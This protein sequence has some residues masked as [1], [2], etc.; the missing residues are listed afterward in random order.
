MEIIEMVNEEYRKRRLRILGMK[1]AGLT[2]KKI[3]EIEGVSKV[4]IYQIIKSAQR[5][6]M[7]ATDTLAHPVDAEPITRVYVRKAGGNGD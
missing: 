6:E 3:A 7:V 5:Y 2:V 4:R 1:R